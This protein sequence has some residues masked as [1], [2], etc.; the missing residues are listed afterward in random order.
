[1][2]LQSWRGDLCW[3]TFHPGETVRPRKHAG[4]TVGLELP[5]HISPLVW[6]YILLTGECW[7][8]KRRCRP[9]LAMLPPAGATPRPS[10]A[11][12]PARTAATRE[13]ASL[14][15]WQPSTGLAMVS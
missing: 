9:W 4:P 14:E 11:H 1:M 13:W 15:L 8:P 6:T 10:L 2:S 5:A 12:G 7:W 3:N